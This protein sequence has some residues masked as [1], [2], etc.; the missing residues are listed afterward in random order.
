MLARPDRL[1]QL[2]REDG[3]YVVEIVPPPT[4]GAGFDQAHATYKAARGYAGGLRMVTGW[5]LVD[6][7]DEA[8]G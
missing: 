3:L 7:C 2:R 5:N 4:E 1:I 8:N 6:L